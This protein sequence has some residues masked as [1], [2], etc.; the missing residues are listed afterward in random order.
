M[1]NEGRLD[2]AAVLDFANDCNFDELAAAL[3][4]LCAAPLKT[5]SELLM[6]V[7]NDAV[8]IPCK[9]ADLQWPTVEAILRNRHGNPSISDGVIKLARKDYTRLSVATAQRT[10]RFLQ[11]RATRADD[12][13]LS[14]MVASRM[15]V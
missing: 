14:T 11:V 2:D 4:L 10:L 3:A 15:D 13:T 9:A 6:G 5:I 12:R 7:R 1:H 8:L